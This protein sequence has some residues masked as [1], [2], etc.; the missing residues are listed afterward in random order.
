MWS[1]C[2][3]SSNRN[4]CFVSMYQDVFEYVVF[5]TNSYD[6]VGA[7][8][9]FHSLFGNTCIHLK[10]YYYWISL[11]STQEK[12]W[13]A[14]QQDPGVLNES[15][16]LPNFKDVLPEEILFLDIS[17][18][19]I[20]HINIAPRILMPDGSDGLNCLQCGKYYPWVNANSDKGYRCYNCNPQIWF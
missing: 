10:S 14:L 19:R 2:F 5:E 20:Q 16:S 12:A 17:K 4:C 8:G 6:S 18:N 1:I 9:N 13:E 11:A 3:A 15:K 7:V